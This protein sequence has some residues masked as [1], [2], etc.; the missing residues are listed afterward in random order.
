MPDTPEFFANYPVSITELRSE[1]TG[2]AKDWTVRDMLID[3]LRDIDAGG[4]MS[5]ASRGMLV[6][7]KVAEDG[8]AALIMSRAGTQNAYESAGLLHQALKNVFAE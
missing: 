7:G 3:A 6:L 8:S 4:P 2:R 1:R 5:H